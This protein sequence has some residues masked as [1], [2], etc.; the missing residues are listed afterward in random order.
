MSTEPTASIRDLTDE[1]FARREAKRQAERIAADLHRLGDRISLISKQFDNEGR[2]AAAIVADI[3]S[4]YMQQT[5]AAGAIFWGLV[6]EL[7]K[8]DRDGPA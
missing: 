2:P 1:Q 8:M 7:S 3:T 6:H 4:D 5:G